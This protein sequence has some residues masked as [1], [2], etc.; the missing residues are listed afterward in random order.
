MKKKLFSLTISLL[1]ALTLLGFS[2]IAF[3]PKYFLFE[4]FVAPAGLFILS[5]GVEENVNTLRYTD[6]FIA[7]GGKRIANFTLMEISLLPLPGGKLLCPSGGYTE[8][9]FFPPQGVDINIDSFDCS[10]YIG[11]AQGSLKVLRHEIY[12][13]IILSG[14]RLENAPI[15]EIEKIEL[16]FVGKTFTGTVRAMGALFTGGGNIKWDLYH[17]ARSYIDATFRGNGVVI[18]LRG[19]LE[20]P[21]IEVR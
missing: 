17:P 13:D 12:G 15:R 5:G 7:Y 11:N 1:I 21:L 3:L 2:L 14:V 18:T 16:H 9:D 6:G 10:P 8:I 20:N 19:T 4:K